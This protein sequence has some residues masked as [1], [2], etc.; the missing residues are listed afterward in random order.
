MTQS[1]SSPLPLPCVPPGLPPLLLEAPPPAHAVPMTLPL[2]PGSG[3]PLTQDPGDRLALAPRNPSVLTSLM[4]QGWKVLFG[5]CGPTGG[6][7]KLVW[8]GCWEKDAGSVGQPVATVPLARGLPG[9]R[10]GVLSPALS[11]C[12]AGRIS[13]SE[14]HGAHVP[15]P[16][17][18]HPRAS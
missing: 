11:P 9:L 14:C 17:T 1:S 4:N 12:K 13:C 6:R 5:F 18:P 10:T 8:T 15:P 2:W 3:S 16:P 7:R